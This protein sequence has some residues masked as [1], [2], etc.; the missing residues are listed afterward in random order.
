[1]V[2]YIDVTVETAAEMISKVT[3]VSDLP[4]LRVGSVTFAL[5]SRA[6]KVLNPLELW[7]LDR[8]LDR[9]WGIHIIY[10][11][12]GETPSKDM[13]PD[14][15]LPKMRKM[16][17]EH[18][19]W[20]IE[21]KK[22]K[23]DQA[24]KEAQQV[25]IENF[26]FHELLRDLRFKVHQSVVDKVG[27]LEGPELRA[28]LPVKLFET[29]IG[30]FTAEVSLALGTVYIKDVLVMVTL[31][32]DGVEQEQVWSVVTVNQPYFPFNINKVMPHL[33]RTLLSSRVV[34]PSSG[35]SSL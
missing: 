2:E 23:A 9:S 32:K 6:D 5:Q 34:R 17:A 15:I 19:E 31:L 13:A 27:Y 24:A 10:P 18:Q 30:P 26:D 3:K 33:L 14:I 12:R 1:M 35:W 16:L 8:E 25:T 22:R 20:A 4:R 28:V 29:E 11:G 7:A 21:A